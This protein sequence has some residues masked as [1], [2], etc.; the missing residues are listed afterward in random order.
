MPSARPHRRLQWL[1]SLQR[2]LGT[3][4]MAP[5]AER[6]FFDPLVPGFTGKLRCFVRQGT[7]PNDN[8]VVLPGR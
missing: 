8:R 3:D 1:R 6:V 2:Q 7:G 4:G 5:S